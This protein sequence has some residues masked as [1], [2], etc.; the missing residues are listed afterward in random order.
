MTEL[1]DDVA[2]GEGDADAIRRSRDDPEAFEIVFRR[3]AAHIH[4]YL[5]LRLG[6]EAAEDLLGETFVA[7]F[8]RRRA[9]D[10]SRPDARPWLYGI[11]TKIIGQHRRTEAREFRLRQAIAPD[12]ADG[13]HADRVANAVTAQACGP[14]L[15][16]ALADLSTG[17]RH[18]LL[19]IAWGQLSYEEVAQVLDIPVGTVRSR[20]NRARTRVKRS[21]GGDVP[22]TLTEQVS[23]G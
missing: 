6:H 1:R 8:R 17:D 13:G 9:Y 10:L 4:R 2:H 14:A 12:R 15:H 5:V 21:I 23:H 22:V 18:V 19:L 11:A 20:L 3:H 16:R 7:A